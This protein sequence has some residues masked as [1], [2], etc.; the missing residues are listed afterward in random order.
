M[1]SAGCE[2]GNTSLYFW[3]PKTEAKIDGSLPV[4]S[5]GDDTVISGYKA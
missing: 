2:T 4:G 3:W 5:G 1:A